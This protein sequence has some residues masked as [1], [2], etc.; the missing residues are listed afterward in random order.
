VIKLGAPQG[1]V[2]RRMDRSAGG[3]S[4]PFLMLNA[5]RRGIIINLQHERGR[6]LGASGSSDVPSPPMSSWRPS[7][8]A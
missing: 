4:Y 8:A 5:N 7:P 6:E 3:A 1:D 2:L